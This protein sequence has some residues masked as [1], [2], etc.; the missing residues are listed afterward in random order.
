MNKLLVLVFA[1]T[2]A[3]AQANPRHH[4]PRHHHG[5]PSWG[6]VVPAIIGGAVVYGATRAATPPPPVYYPIPTGM[7]TPP[8]GYHYE[9]LNDANCNC[10]RWVLVPNQ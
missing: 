8:Y 4:G 1:L 7:P 2:C 10:I 5:G 9:Q 3:V 6:W